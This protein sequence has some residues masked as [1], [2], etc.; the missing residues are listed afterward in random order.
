[1]LPAAVA[2][3]LLPAMAKTSKD[4]D[5]GRV[6]LE[7]PSGGRS[8]PH[9]PALGSVCTSEPGE[10]GIKRLAAPSIRRVAKRIRAV[11]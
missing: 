6:G 8:E 1:M 5:L 3:V 4:L 2:S 9:Y 7:Q 10:L 11:R